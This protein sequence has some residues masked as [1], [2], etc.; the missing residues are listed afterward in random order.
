MKTKFVK[1][2]LCKHLSTDNRCF[3]FY[4]P[5]LSGINKGDAVIVDTKNGEKN[6]IVVSTAVVSKDDKDLIDL[7]MNATGSSTEV[8]R[9]ISKVTYMDLDYSDYEEENNE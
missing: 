4:A 1:F 9:V 5:W 7:I 3:L 8:K 2:V 6:A